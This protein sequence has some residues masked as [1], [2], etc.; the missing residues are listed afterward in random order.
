MDYKRARCR[1]GIAVVCAVG[2]WDKR[3][4]IATGHCAKRK[5]EKRDREREKKR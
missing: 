3:G 5:K 1:V 4:R 2:V